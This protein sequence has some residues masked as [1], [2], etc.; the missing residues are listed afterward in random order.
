MLLTIFE[1]NVTN[2]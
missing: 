1:D 2:Y